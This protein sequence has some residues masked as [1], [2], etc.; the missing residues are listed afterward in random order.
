MSMAL[1]G[2]NGDTQT[3]IQTSRS[4][5]FAIYNSKTNDEIKVSKTSKPIS[6]WISKDSS[7]S[8]PSF[9]FVNVLNQSNLTQNK[10]QL[11]D[12]FL[13]M[14]FRLTSTNVSIHIQIKP[15]KN[16]SLS[17]YLTLLKYGDNPILS[18][19]N[20]DTLQL[21]CPQDLTQ[22][23]GDEPFYLLF[24]NMSRVYSFNKSYIGI[25][26]LELNTSQLNCK[27]KLKNSHQ[28]LSPQNGTNTFTNNFEMRM[29][30]A[31]C[32]Y[33]DTLTNTWTSYGMEVMSDTNL[34]HTHC[35]SNHLTTFAG[36][37][38]VLPPAIDFNY[39]WSHASFLD[40]PVIYSTVIVLVCLYV[41]LGVWA[42][43]V[44]TKDNKKQGFTVVQT[45]NSDFCL[46]EKQGAK[47]YAYEMVVFTGARPNAATKSM[48]FI[49]NFYFNK[50]LHLKKN[51]KIN[52]FKVSCIVSSAT[53]STG[54]LDLK[55]TKR[56][57]F[58]RGAIDSFI[59]LH[60]G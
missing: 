2:N 41:A 55:D 53:Q 54:K 22:Q 20:Y 8:I 10:Y 36:G 15:S 59:I 50:D 4:L 9:T 6:M 60:D 38:I 30:T 32:Y 19:N 13:L 1:T 46:R 29:F 37:F 40:N 17:S 12:G 57:V 34:T 5:S 43:W 48:V 28:N 25:S 49:F 18:T 31:G 11:K 21:F 39:A 27:N 58:S 44:D 23:N 42:R 56:K 24:E 26:I 52:G 35:I 33:T 16:N 14:G 47:Y 51:T 3:N 45:E 7:V